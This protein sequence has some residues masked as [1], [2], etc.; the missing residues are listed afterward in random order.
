MTSQTNNEHFEPRLKGKRKVGWEPKSGK[1]FHPQKLIS[2]GATFHRFE[3]QNLK[4]LIG[5]W[6]SFEENFWCS[7]VF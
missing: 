6:M 1:K 7:I 2:F 5:I 4:N 3:K